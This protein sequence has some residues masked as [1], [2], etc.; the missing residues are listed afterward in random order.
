[1][2]IPTYDLVM[3]KVMTKSRDFQ[4]LVTKSHDWVNDRHITGSDSCERQPDLATD[5]DGRDDAAHCILNMDI[6]GGE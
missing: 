3:T 4:W 2:V 1:V 6:V 5:S